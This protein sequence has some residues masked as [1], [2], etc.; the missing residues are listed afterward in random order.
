MGMVKKSTRTARS[1]LAQPTSK[2]TTIHS[3]TMAAEYLEKSKAGVSRERLSRRKTDR[4]R[5]YS[6][7][8]ACRRP[9][10]YLPNTC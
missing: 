6:S 7:T 1:Q 2:K 10:K 8:C 4:K 9:V 5:W 3:S